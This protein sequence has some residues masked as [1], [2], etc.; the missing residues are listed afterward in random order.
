MATRA[1]IAGSVAGGVVV[2]ATVA[3]LIVAL[4]LRRQ[5]HKH[6]MATP[7]QFPRPTELAP[8]GSVVESEHQA[9]P[10][11]SDPSSLEKEEWGVGRPD[12]QWASS[13]E[14]AYSD[15]NPSQLRDDID[16][17]S[18]P[19][20]VSQTKRTTWTSA[21]AR[22]QIDSANTYEITSQSVEAPRDTKATPSLR[23][24]QVP[25]SASTERLLRYTGPPPEY[26]A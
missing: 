1:L 11:A 3:A 4:W 2:A 26:K 21:N 7:I 13:V 17:H 20:A 14:T 10:S 19:R 9:A 22:S 8:E 16:G 18:L 6:Q 24:S 23:R 12:Q 5:R 25:V 15:P